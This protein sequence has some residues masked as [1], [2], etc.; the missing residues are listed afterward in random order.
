MGAVDMDLV[1][2]KQ[3][4]VEAR[5]NFDTPWFEFE[6]EG[7]YTLRI[8]PPFGDKKQFWLEYQKSFKVGPNQKI[9]VPLSQFGQECPLQKRIDALNKA[10]DELSKKE[11]SRIRPK[12]RVAMFVIDRKNEAKGPQIFETNLDVFRDI[13]TIMADPEFGDITHPEKG[14]DISVNY[15]PGKKTKNGFPEWK[16][17]PRR[18]SSPLSTNPQQQSQ[19]LE[20][21]LFDEY[22][23]GQ[24]SEAAYIEAVLAG[25]EAAYIQQ[26]KEQRQQGQTAASS[27]PVAAPAAPAA[28]PP[29][30]AP[31]ASPVVTH[32][33]LAGTKLWQALNG[34]V[35]E[36]TVEKVC[37][38]LKTEKPESVML[39]KQDGMN[40][41]QT[42]AQ[43]GFAVSIPAPA[44]PAAPSPPMSPPMAPPP[45]PSYP[46]PPGD[47]IPFKT[48]PSEETSL[49]A[50]L[51]GLATQTGPQSQVAQDIAAAL[52]R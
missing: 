39:M 21:D 14:T 23:V 4:E 12:T 40:Q 31:A 28:P 29:L 9:V 2:Q 7:I 33:F 16:P 20:K 8:L 10:G 24:A 50:Q 46:P 13:L 30:A 17:Q 1:R 37:E 35:T 27:A 32:Q 51:A 6:D 49:A 45:M 36:T 48:P 26:R 11:A 43:M 38:R 41:W 5:T 52:G 42:A 15:T 44:A 19:W 47:E 3:A 34:Q 25:T 18:N 22:R